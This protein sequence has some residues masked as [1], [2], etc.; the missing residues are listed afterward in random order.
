MNFL[1]VLTDDFKLGVVQ[2]TQG[3]K[4]DDVNFPKEFGNRNRS[5]QN[6]IQ[7]E[8]KTKTKTKAVG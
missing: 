7:F 6:V 2:Q 5:E 4:K 8:K 1:T 3:G